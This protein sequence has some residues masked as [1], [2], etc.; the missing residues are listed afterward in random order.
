MTTPESGEFWGILGGTFD[1]VHKGHI[2]LALDCLKEKNLDGVLCIPSFLHPFKKNVVSA[3]FEDRL[4][5]LRQTVSD[6]NRFSISTIEKDESLS[7][8]SIDTIRAVKK[9]NSLM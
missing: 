5:M 3:S 4:Q 8:Y 2:T 9:R 1:P 7:G 6:D